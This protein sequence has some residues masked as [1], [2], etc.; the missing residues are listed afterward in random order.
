MYQ[1]FAIL[2]VLY[3]YLIKMYTQIFEI[4]VV[5]YTYLIKMYTY[6]QREDQWDDVL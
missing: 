5:L 3:T 6:E 4:L 1:I 2:V